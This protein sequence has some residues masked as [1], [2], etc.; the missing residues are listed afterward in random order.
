MNIGEAA[1]KS[2]L[3][4]KTVRYYD[5]I[6]L[7]KEDKRIRVLIISANGPS[8]CSG[9]DLKEINSNKNKNDYDKLFNLCSEVMLSLLKIGRAHV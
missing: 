7:I 1:K 5:E 8:F 3:T 2:G 9:H 6:N 4:V